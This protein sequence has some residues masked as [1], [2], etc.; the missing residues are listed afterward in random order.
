LA[1]VV[2]GVW[3]GGGGGGVVGWVGVLFWGGG[4]WVGGL[5]SFWL[6][7]GGFGWVF[8]LGGVLGGVGCLSLFSSNKADS[9]WRPPFFFFFSV[10]RETLNCGPSSFAFLPSFLRERPPCLV[11]FIFCGL[12]RAF[13]RALCSLSG[14]SC[15]G[16]RGPSP[17]GA[18]FPPLSSASA[19]SGGIP[20]EGPSFN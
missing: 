8:F 16:A 20:P 17:L 5:V 9:L 10:L 15:R 2:G 18:V 12:G 1:F 13:Y 6:V 3:G 19:P 11:S 14:V 4:G 7:G